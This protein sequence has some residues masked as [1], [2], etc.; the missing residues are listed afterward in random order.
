[1]LDKVLF[2]RVIK[3]PIHFRNYHLFE[4]FPKLYRHFFFLG[5]IEIN[6]QIR[7]LLHGA[8]PLPEIHLDFIIPSYAGT[9]QI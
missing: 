8:A 1:M 6:G 7:P 3:M 5:I 2:N 9:T 4:P